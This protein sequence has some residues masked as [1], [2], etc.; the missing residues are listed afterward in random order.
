MFAF[1]FPLSYVVIVLLV[2]LL[3]AVVANWAAKSWLKRDKAT[4]KIQGAMVTASQILAGWKLPRLAKLV[5]LAAVKDIS[6]AIEGVRTLITEV[7]DADDKE[8]KMLELMEAHHQYAF[9]L[10]LARTDD[11]AW[12]LDQVLRDPTARAE[13]EEMLAEE[14]A[15]HAPV[16]AKP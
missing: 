16:A 6:G 10:R 15:G 8:A 4:D 9:P 2:V 13:L 3:C 11:R 5:A 7:L 1:V 14:T 12:I